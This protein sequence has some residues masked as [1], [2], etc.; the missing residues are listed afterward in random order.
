MG[1]DEPKRISAV[2]FLAGLARHQQII[3]SPDLFARVKVG[4]RFEFGGATYEV[5]L[6]HR[7]R[8]VDLKLVGDTDAPG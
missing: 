2:E 4:D 3:L 1:D 8:L 7:I 5:T 6:M